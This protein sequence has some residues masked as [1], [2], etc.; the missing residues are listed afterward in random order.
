MHERVQY[1]VYE[2]VMTSRRLSPPPRPPALAAPLR[3]VLPPI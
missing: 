3:R 2:L 1:Y